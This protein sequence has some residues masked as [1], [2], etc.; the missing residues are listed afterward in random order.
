MEGLFGYKFEKLTTLTFFM[1]YEIII[2]TIFF[3]LLHNQNVYSQALFKS[4]TVEAS[5]DNDFLN[6]IGKRTDRYYTNGMNLSVYYFQPENRKFF[7]DKMLWSFKMDTSKK[8]GWGITQKI[9]TPDNVFNPIHSTVDFP[10]SGSLYTI[11][12]LQSVNTLKNAKFNSEIWIGVL[13]PLSIAEGTQWH[14]HMLIKIR[15]AKGWESQ[16]QNTVILN[17]K[18]KYDRKI[19]STQYLNIIGDVEGNAGTLLNQLGSGVQM[20]LGKLTDYFD[21]KF[22]G[23]SFYF[24]CSSR[25]NFVLYNANLQGSIFNSKTQTLVEFEPLERTLPASEINN[26]YTENCLG[27]HLNNKL[28]SVSYNQFFWSQSTKNTESHSYGSLTIAMKVK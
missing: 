25:L 6:V 8:Y 13:G 24:T 1:K 19:V 4:T 27:V 20:R 5:I 21:L 10:Y 3:Q 14:Y 11:H 22:E 17:Y 2:L 23:Y 12:S 28:F 26:F 7:L 9:F 18:L 15:I 16:I